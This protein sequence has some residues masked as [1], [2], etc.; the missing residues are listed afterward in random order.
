[1]CPICTVCATLYQ[2]VQSYNWMAYGTIAA[3]FEP[4][5]MYWYGI[6]HNVRIWPLHVLFYVVKLWPKWYKDDNYCKEY[7]WDYRKKLKTTGPVL[8]F[9]HIKEVIFSGAY[10]QHPP[11]MGFLFAG[12]GFVYSFLQILLQDSTPCWMAM[13]FPP[14]SVPGTFNR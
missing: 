1:M 13:Y 10:P 4:I 2:C 5:T 8:L 7:A 11:D 12:Q 9:V 3:C 6:A 14:S